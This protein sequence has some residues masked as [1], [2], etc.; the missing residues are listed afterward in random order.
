MTDGATGRG[1][2][3]RA[4][5]FAA[6]TTALAAVA[7]WLGGGMVAGPAAL[8][9]AV[10]GAA[11]LG[12]YVVPRRRARTV[13]LSSIA[14]QIAL[15]VGFAASMGGTS[16]MSMLLCGHGPMTRAPAV[17]PLTLAAQHGGLAAE[18]LSTRGLPMLAAHVVAAALCGAWMHAGERLVTELGQLVAG[19]LRP[20]LLLA[21]GPSRRVRPHTGCLVR[22]APRH[23]RGRAVGAA[24]LRGPP[25]LLP[26]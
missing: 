13:V 22:Q 18:L 5:L 26:C 8:A 25:R 24:G 20:G 11:V 2:A 4:L 12:W 3:C 16:A 23:L 9:A 10:A 1:R 6:V 21:L 15:H 14:A 17:V 19:A 7:H